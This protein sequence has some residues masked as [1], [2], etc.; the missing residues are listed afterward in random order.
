[1]LRSGL[2]N[3]NSAAYLQRQRLS[4]IGQLTDFFQTLYTIFQRE[5][6]SEDHFI[7]LYLLILLVI[8]LMKIICS[9]TDTIIFAE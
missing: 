2:P 4:E 8:Q 6:I 5:R 7:F 1:M 3:L 9:K